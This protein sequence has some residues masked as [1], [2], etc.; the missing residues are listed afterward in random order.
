MGKIIS[1]LKTIYG[2]NVNVEHGDAN[3]T[4]IYNKTYNLMFSMN[5]TDVI[6]VVAFGVVGT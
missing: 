1:S 3:I 5:N 2:D 4:H 6:K